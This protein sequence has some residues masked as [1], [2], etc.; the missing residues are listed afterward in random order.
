MRRSKLEIHLD[1]LKALAHGP[2]KITHIA[3]KTAINCKDLK[4]RLE[5]LIKQNLVEERA[6]GKR[7]LYIITERGMTVLKNLRQ[8]ETAL[9]IA[10]TTTQI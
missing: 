9:P 3:Y 6:A 2:L 7:T 1:V 5:F 8:L 4:Q 10:Y